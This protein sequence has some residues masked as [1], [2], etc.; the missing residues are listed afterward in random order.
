[1][2]LAAAPPHR[3]GHSGIAG[4]QHSFAWI[5]SWPAHRPRRRI[6]DSHSSAGCNRHARRLNRHGRD[7]IPHAADE[8]ALYRGGACVYCRSCNGSGLPHHPG[9]GRQRL[10]AYERHSYRLRDH[11]WMGRPRCEFAAHRG[12]CRRRSHP[13]EEGPAPDPWRRSPAWSGTQASQILLPGLNASFSLPLSWPAAWW[14]FWV[15]LASQA[16]S[17]PVSWAV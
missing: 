15:A 4:S 1:V 14:S 7:H 13:S 11:L 12:N 5:R 16:P 6:A 2:E 17:S 8:Q 10:P 3:P 9:H